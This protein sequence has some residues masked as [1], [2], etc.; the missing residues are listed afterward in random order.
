MY[1]KRKHVVEPP[2]GW[3]KR[4][5][6]FRAFSLRGIEKVR[7]EWSLVCLALNLKRMNQRIAW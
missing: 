5:L 2:Y 1:A 3:I 4:C 6:G 7:G